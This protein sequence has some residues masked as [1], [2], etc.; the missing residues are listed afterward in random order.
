[1][2]KISLVN[3]VDLGKFDVSILECRGS[4]FI[5][6]GEGL[7]MTTPTERSFRDAMQKE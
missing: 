6:R 7:A 3:A 5:V 2:A 4:F 1:M